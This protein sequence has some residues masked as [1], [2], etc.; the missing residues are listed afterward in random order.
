M[1]TTLSAPV[2][3]PVRIT[4]ATAA[5][6]AR[7]AAFALRN[8]TLWTEVAAV[9]SLDD[10]DH[11]CG[12]GC[13]IYARRQ[14]AVTQYALIHSAT[15]GCQLGRSAQTREVRVSVAPKAER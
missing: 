11:N 1:T 8:T 3:N 7:T 10:Q 5:D 13:K 15:Y 4:G 14:G 2:T 9:D 6:I 12:H